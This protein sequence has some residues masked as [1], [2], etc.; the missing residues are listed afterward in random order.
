MTVTRYYFHLE[1]RKKRNIISHKETI[2]STGDWVY[3]LLEVSLVMV[4]PYPWLSGKHD[5]DL[6]LAYSSKGIKVYTQSLTDDTQI[7]YHINEILSLLSMLRVGIVLRVI[8]MTSIWN[9]NRAQR[10]LV[11]TN[12]LCTSYFSLFLLATYALRVSDGY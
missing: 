7:Y 3:L 1:F 6:Q 12:S 11:C 4:I 10:N 2:V 5:T 8:L 9:G